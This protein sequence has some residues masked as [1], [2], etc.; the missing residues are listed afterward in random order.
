MAERERYGRRAALIYGTLI[1]A[2]LRPLRKAITQACR[3]EGAADVLDIACATGAQCRHL[4]RAGIHATGV[5]LSGPMVA[6]ARR[7]GGADT[8]YLLGS[9]LDLPIPAASY[10]AVLLSLALHEHPEDERAVMLREALRVL[11]PRGVLLVADF[12]RPAR[13]RLHAPWA[14]VRLIERSAGPEHH[15]GFCDFVQHGSLEGLLAR[16][17]LTPSRVTR[18]VFGTVSIAVVRPLAGT[19]PQALSN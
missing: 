5:D 19:L 11:R 6:S 2:A 16:R 7:R 9:A 18:A 10:D 3:A 17:G 13:T 8:D 4:A 12:A 15:T 1:D 14:I